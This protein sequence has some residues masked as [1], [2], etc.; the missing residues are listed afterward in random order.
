MQMFDFALPKKVLLRKS[1]TKTTEKHENLCTIYEKD[2]KGILT[3]R[4]EF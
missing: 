2:S 1:L 4:G 3:L